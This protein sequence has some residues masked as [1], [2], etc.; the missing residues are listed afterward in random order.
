MTTKPDYNA[1]MEL[2]GYTPANRGFISTKEVEFI[3]EVLELNSRTEI[4][5]RN[6][7][8]AA[9]VWMGMKADREMED[10]N[11]RDGLAWMDKMSAVCRVVDEKLW[12]MGA[13]V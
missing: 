10:G 6:I 2:K 8:N 1:I 3:T 13:E 5:L 11:S 12:N 7:R 9:V 4:E